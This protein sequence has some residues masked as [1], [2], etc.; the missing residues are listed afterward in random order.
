LEWLKGH[1]GDIENE[2]CDRL[3]VRSAEGSQLLIDD[4]YE[5]GNG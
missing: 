1:A 4:G 3:A 2:I 5:N